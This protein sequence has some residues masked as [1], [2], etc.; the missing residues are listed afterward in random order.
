MLLHPKELFATIG[1][2]ILADIKKALSQER[3]QQDLETLLLIEEPEEVFST[4]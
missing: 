4:Q 2:T 1:K 3:I